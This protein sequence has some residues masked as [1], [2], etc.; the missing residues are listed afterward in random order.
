MKTPDI[1]KLLA[2]PLA[3]RT[4][5]VALFVLAYFIVCVKLDKTVSGAELAC[6]AGFAVLLQLAYLVNKLDDRSEDAFNGEPALFEGPRQ[7][8]WRKI[9]IYSFVA[10]AAALAVFRPAL[11]SVLAYSAVVTFAYG[12]P[13]L[14]LKGPL[15]LKPFINTLNFFVVAFMVPFLLRDPGAWAYAPRLLAGSGRLLLAVLCLTLLFDVRDMRGDERAGICTVPVVAG[16]S[17]LLWALA[18][19]MLYFLGIDLLAGS[20]VLAANQAL[21]SVFVLGALKERGRRYYDVMVLAEGVFLAVR[22]KANIG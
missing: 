1:G 7:E 9:F 12:H 2:L 17:R 4:H 3:A 16:R 14:R 5:V 15:L 22:L 10:A 13:A 18:A 6:G 19:V 21:L 8:T 20:Y 11:L